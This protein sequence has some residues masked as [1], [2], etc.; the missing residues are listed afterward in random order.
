M[1]MTVSLTQNVFSL[2]IWVRYV[3]FLADIR[4]VLDLKQI[5]SL[6]VL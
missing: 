1:T 5:A 4:I 3:H 6:T 2:Y